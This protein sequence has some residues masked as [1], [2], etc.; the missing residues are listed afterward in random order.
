MPWW[1]L[2]EYWRI[3]MPFIHHCGPYSKQLG[4]CCAS[5][6]PWLTFTILLPLIWSIE[7]R[8]LC[9]CVCRLPLI[10]PEEALVIQK[11]LMDDRLH[12]PSVYIVSKSLF[13]L[14]GF[15]PLLWPHCCRFG[16][17]F[18]MYGNRSFAIVC[19]I[20]IKPEICFYAMKFV[21]NTFISL[22][23]LLWHICDD[24]SSLTT[25]WN[26]HPNPGPFG[27][28]NEHTVVSF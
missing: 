20:R 18:L 12:L 26:F 2:G 19:I 9:L 11:I 3:G 22:Y 8:Y 10:H 28:R 13:L 25:P 5:F 24:I 4:R 27:C 7:L 15:H 1:S 16:E 14:S 17:L 23:E 6:C 21:F